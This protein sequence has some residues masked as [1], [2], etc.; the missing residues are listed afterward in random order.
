MPVSVAELPPRPFEDLTIEDVQQRVRDVLDEEGETLTLELKEDPADKSSIA[1]AC[2]AFAN[3]IGGLLVAGMSD[4]GALI[5]ARPVA[6][7]P[8]VWIK[9]ILQPRVMPLPP[10]R[11][12]WLDGPVGG[13]L[14]VLVESSTSTPHILLRTGSIYVRS[15]GSSHP[16]PI[17]DQGTLLE[18]IERAR[19]AR[20][21][22]ERDAQ[23]HVGS[24]PTATNG[25]ALV[26]LRATGVADD[27]IDRVTTDH[28]APLATALTAAAGEPDLY[29]TRIEHEW[30]QQYV[31]RRHVAGLVQQPDHGR[32]GHNLEGRY[33]HLLEALPRRRSR[34]TTAAAPREPAQSCQPDGLGSDNM[35]SWSRPSYRWRVPRRP[36]PRLPRTRDP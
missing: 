11:A 30:Q 16:V 33:G 14:L 12:R 3:T 23:T 7:E 8:Q 36:S 31:T 2:T 35:E 32:R 24:L 19:G 15:P 9:D 10:F 1:K 5:G 29:D 26:V 4:D 6:G 17:R 34:A 20:V 18:L 25:S 27:W 28:A 13:V 22:A 21:E